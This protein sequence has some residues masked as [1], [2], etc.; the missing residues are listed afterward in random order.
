[1]GPNGPVDALK[2]DLSYPHPSDLP[3]QHIP[4]GEILPNKRQQEWLAR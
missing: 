3:F 2:L 4:A 1:M